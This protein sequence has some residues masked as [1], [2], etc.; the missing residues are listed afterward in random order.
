MSVL[1]IIVCYERNQKLSIRPFFQNFEI[2]AITD[3][4]ELSFSDSY[5]LNWVD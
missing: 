4:D 1:S 2:I 5:F 3:S